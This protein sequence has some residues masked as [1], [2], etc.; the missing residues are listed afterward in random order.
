MNCVVLKRIGLVGHRTGMGRPKEFSREEILPKALAVFWEKGLSETTV[1]DIERATGV[2]KSGLYSEFKNK[3]DIFLASLQYYLENRGGEPVLSAEP[4]GWDNIQRF[5]EIGLTCFA[6]RRGCFSVNSM[7]DVHLLP[8]QG[9]EMIAAKNGG[10]KRLIAAN[11][12]AEASSA[13]SGS[14]A[15]I[16]LTFYSGM[17]IEQN[18]DPSNTSTRRKIHSFMDYLRHSA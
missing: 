10:L 14:L 6:G 2:N 1:Q 5:L 16:I 15:D 12:K 4:R 3:E 8:P 7:R 13:N 9:H 18:M 11:I 17:C